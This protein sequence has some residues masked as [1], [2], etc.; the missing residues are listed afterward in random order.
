MQQLLQTVNEHDTYTVIKATVICVSFRR[1]KVIQHC[2]KNQNV[3]GLYIS[4]VASICAM[5]SVLMFITSSDI[6]AI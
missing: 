1:N 6:N 2:K 4:Y 3:N 5:S